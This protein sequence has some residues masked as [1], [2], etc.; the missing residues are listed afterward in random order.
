[1]TKILY[2]LYLFITSDI[3]CKTERSRKIFPSP[4]SKQVKG[5]T[6]QKVG[7]SKLNISKCQLN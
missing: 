2:S 5:Q 6:K 3:L 1:M 4:A 7:E